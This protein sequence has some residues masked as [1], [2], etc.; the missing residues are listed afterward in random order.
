MTRKKS[1]V[2][3]DSQK[4]EKNIQEENSSEDSLDL[5]NQKLTTEILNGNAH[6]L[7]DDGLTG[8][9]MDL[10][11]SDN[12]YQNT[13]SRGGTSFQSFDDEQQEQ[14]EVFESFDK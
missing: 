1:W 4:W 7:K 8:E 14:D 5:N 10:K 9:K 6:V 11:P 13:R 3:D 2:E 12:F